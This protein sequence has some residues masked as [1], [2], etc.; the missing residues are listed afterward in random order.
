[1]Q[2]GEH[3]Q[4]VAADGSMGLIHRSSLLERQPISMWEM[5]WFHGAISRLDA[6]KLLDRNRDGQF[7]LRTSQN[8]KGVYALAI[9]Q[10]PRLAGVVGNLSGSTQVCPVQVPSSSAQLKFPDSNTPPSQQFAWET[11]KVMIGRSWSIIR[12]APAHS[13]NHTHL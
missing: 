4:A 8:T 2:D 7:L 1:M 3:Y 13:N 11:S 10:A 5:P 6:E 9:R 12:P